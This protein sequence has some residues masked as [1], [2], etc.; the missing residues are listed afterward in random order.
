MNLV[1]PA[2]D[3]VAPDRFSSS[4]EYAARFAG[5][6]GAYLVDA[7]NQLIARFLGPATGQSVLDVGGGHG[8]L[9]ET[10]QS[11]NFIIT[12]HGSDNT[13][14][15]Q[16]D[17]EQFECQTGVLT[18]LPYADQQFD[19]VISVRMIPHLD[20]W[21]EVIGE[22]CRVCRYRVIIEYPPKLGF[23]ALTPLLFGAKK[24]V[25]KNTRPYFLFSHAEIA[26]VFERH[27]FCVEQ[28]DSE[29]LLPFVIHRILKAAPPLRWLET[30]FCRIGLTRLLGSPTILLATRRAQLK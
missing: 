13:C 8:Q 10:Y 26:A 14:F 27:G 22:L 1:D 23:N 17:R 5:D 12:I 30:L 19:S 3:T 4:D 24:R 29:L 9:L 16:V 20:A 6:W 18:E 11:R 25:E 7:Q 15:E 28:R 21:Q 2:L